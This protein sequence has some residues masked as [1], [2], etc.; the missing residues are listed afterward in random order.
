MSTKLIDAIEDGIDKK[1]KST[2]QAYDEAIEN[3]TND[4]LGYDYIRA[5]NRI[6]KLRDLFEEERTKEKQH[7]KK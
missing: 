6:V 1:I 2:I 3:L 5:R 4:Q 7:K